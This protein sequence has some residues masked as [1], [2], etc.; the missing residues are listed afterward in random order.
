MNRLLAALAGG[1]CTAVS[2]MAQSTELSFTIDGSGS[3]SNAEFDLQ[4]EGVAQ[5]IE[6]PAVIPQ[7]GSVAVT[8]VQ[9]G[10]PGGANL[11]VPLVTIDSAA[12][13]NAT[14]AAVR[15]INQIGGSTPM[16]TAIAGSV[17]ALAGGN[18]AAR[19]VICLS[20]DG[21]ANNDAAALAAADA[22]LIAGVERID[23]IAVGNGVDLVFLDQLRRGG[24]QLFPVAD[25][26]EFRD[27]IGIKVAEILRVAC[28]PVG[29]RRPGSAL[30]Y[31]IHRS[32]P[33]WFTILSVVNTNTLPVSLPGA[34]DGGTTAVHFE[35]VNTTP[36]PADPLCPSS[37]VVFNRHELLTPAD[38]HSVLTRCSN[39]FAPGGQQGYLVVSAEDPSLSPGAHWAFNHLIG[40]E[41]VLN[42]SGVCYEVN[43]VSICSPLV[44]GAQTDLDGN[45]DLDFNDIEYASLPDKMLIDSFVALAGSHL[46]LLS[47][48][49]RFEDLNTIRFDVFN[50][51][52]MALSAQI[53]FCCWFDQPLAT[54]H[55]LFAESFLQTVPNDPAE[56]ALLCD[57]SVT[58][59]TGWAVI[60]SLRVQSRAGATITNDGPLLGMISAG[61]TTAISGG[62]LL[63]GS[64]ARQTNGDFDGF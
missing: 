56:L 21:M 51:N 4:L 31:P 5:S 63:W 29:T 24:G 59:E 60:E 3:I 13:A 8:V 7:N 53:T 27:S 49:G 39:A 6:T 2:L 11:E 17:A 40:S 12:T 26:N 58:L 10:T 46:T 64:E 33:T 23:T 48:V 18:P 43:A 32:G 62:H 34:V 47:L 25:F 28:P 30:I 14:A 57:G 42:S 38:V 16:A 19:Q 54:V 55:P 45:G 15:A 22:A 41:L 44:Q 50:D 9:F 52:E 37:C 20:T 36:N 61:P 1:L 35:Y